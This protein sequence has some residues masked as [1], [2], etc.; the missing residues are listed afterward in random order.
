MSF[1]GFLIRQGPKRNKRQGNVALIPISKVTKRPPR[2]PIA[3][4]LR[5]AHFPYYFALNLFLFLSSCF[6]SRISCCETHKP[7]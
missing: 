1:W 6:Q 3:D 5:M 7:K 2:V 4:I